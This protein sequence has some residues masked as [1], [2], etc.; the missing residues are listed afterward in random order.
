MK[1]P[2]WS[3]GPV[4]FW[5]HHRVQF[6]GNLDPSRAALL[7]G[8]ILIVGL[9]LLGFLGREIWFAVHPD[10]RPLRRKR[11]REKNHA[12]RGDHAKA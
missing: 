6:E 3:C 7:I 4:I 5:F 8:G 2:V 11:R 9:P 12:R 10:K 1:M